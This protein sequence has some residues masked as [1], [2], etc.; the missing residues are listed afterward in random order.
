MIYCVVPRDLAEKLH[1]P[2]RRHFR[3]D[4]GVEVI[5]ERR[6]ADRRGGSDRRR[7]IDESAIG[8]AG[9]DPV[10]PGREAQEAAGDGV[11]ERRV[12]PG[13]AGRR[14]A[15]RRARQVHVQPPRSLPRRAQRHAERLVF[16]QRVVAPDERAEDAQA[17]RLVK[18]WQGGD[19]GAFSEL[20]VRYFDRVFSYLRLVLRDY[21]E[22]EDLAQDT[23]AKVARAMPRYELRGRPFRAWLF[24][25]ARNEAISFLRRQARLEVAEPEEIERRM[26]EQGELT[27]DE[28]PLIGWIQDRDL[29]LFVERLP[30]A[31]RQVL[32]LRYLLDLDNAQIGAVMG[33]SREEV[34]ALHY[35]AVTTLRERLASVGKGP[36]R[37]EKPAQATQRFKQAEV[38]RH[39]RFALWK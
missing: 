17:A 3:A 28:V 34:K 11:G 14:V 35:R 38:L 24:V 39:R 33:R 10:A 30:E 5:V 13:I 29:M 32:G 21:H 6:D 22:A 16:V 27:E 15:E 20:Y 9:D 36:E 8:P 7:A 26:E 18:R 2:L 4:E 31:Q 19:E 37:S 12:L 25:V 23:F 1:E